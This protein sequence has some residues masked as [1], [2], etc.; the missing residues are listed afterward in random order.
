[1]VFDEKR[2]IDF[3]FLVAGITRIVIIAKN[4]SAVNESMVIQQ[5]DQL[6]YDKRDEDEI[7]LSEQKLR[8]VLDNSIGAI[9]LVDTFYRILLA[10]EKA[11]KIVR[12]A[13]EGSELNE[14]TYFPDILPA[15]RREYVK[16]YS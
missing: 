13:S 5:Q 3:T 1:M 8:S 10:N 7:I 14:G 4:N 6:S 16:G 15:A 9:F 12:L 2:P 11:K